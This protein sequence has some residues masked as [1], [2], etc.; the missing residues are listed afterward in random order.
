MLPVCRVGRTGD[1]GDGEIWRIQDRFRVEDGGGGFQYRI[2]RCQSLQGLSICYAANN[3]LKMSRKVLPVHF[4]LLFFSRIKYFFAIFLITKLKV[5]YVKYRHN[6]IQS[7][8]KSQHTQQNSGKSQHSQKNPA[9]DQVIQQKSVIALQCFDG[10]LNPA[11]NGLYLLMRQLDHYQISIRP[12]S[13]QD[14]CL[15]KIWQ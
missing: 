9:K 12:R 14:Q 7:A 2:H 11:L 3:C 6:K 1:Y 5:Y 8:L 13:D 4:F 15:I 10:T